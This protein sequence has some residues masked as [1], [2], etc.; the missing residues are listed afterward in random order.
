MELLATGLC[1]A[2]GHLRAPACR[3]R[4]RRLE[5]DPAPSPGAVAPSTTLTV[6]KR[7]HAGSPAPHLGPPWHTH[8]SLVGTGARGNFAG[9]QHENGPERRR[10][11]A[12]LLSEDFLG[13]A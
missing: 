4:V 2:G 1:G 10:R 8:P 12:A 6:S 13:F 7:V 5:V 3:S 9:F 11:S